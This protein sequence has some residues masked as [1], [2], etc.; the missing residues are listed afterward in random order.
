MHCYF[1][2][3]TGEVEIQGDSRDITERKY[4]EEEL[5]R[6]ATTDELTKIFNRRYFMSEAQDEQRSAARHS[7]PYA[8]AIIDLDHFKT[9]NDTY[10]HAV[11]DLALLAFTEICTKCIREID[12]FAR[13]GGDEFA[14]LLPQT[15]RA[16]ATLVIER[17]HQSVTEKSSDLGG[18]RVK[19]TL[20]TGLACSTDG[21]ETLEALIIR[22]D[23]ALYRAKEA[24]R[25]QI[26]YDISQ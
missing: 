6:Q 22:A 24:G 2:P 12:I 17:I 26:G 21:H 9:I 23:Q 5:N 1:N 10:G 7:Q 15:T 18:N 14:L 3:T 11:G 13:F 16:Q 8:I 19:I 20:T 25:N 4:L